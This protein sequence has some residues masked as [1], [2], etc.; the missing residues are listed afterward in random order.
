[1]AREKNKIAAKEDKPDVNEQRRG[2]RL[3]GNI[4]L[5]DA[6]S[7][8]TEVSDVSAPTRSLH[9]KQPSLERKSNSLGATEKSLKVTKS[10]N[11]LRKDCE[12]ISDDA[13][14]SPGVEKDLGVD[15]PVLPKAS[16]LNQ[17]PPPSPPLPDTAKSLS[18]VAE[19]AHSGT[20]KLGRILTCSY[21]GKFII[22]AG[23]Y[24]VQ[25]V[26][27][28]CVSIRNPKIIAEVT[29]SHHPAPSNSGYVSCC[30]IL[31]SHDLTYLNCM[32]AQHGRNCL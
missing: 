8:V 18:R 27:L 6:A 13:P 7:S 32:V 15:T 2:I 20:L 4:D 21:G 23:N 30:Y 14:S 1:V 12:G 29:R 11:D 9:G 19:G 5:H 22:I 17:E 24:V 25:P 10:L 26:L 31:P 16:P 28:T 3:N